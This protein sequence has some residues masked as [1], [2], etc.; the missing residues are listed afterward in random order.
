MQTLRIV[1]VQVVDS[2]DISI[3]FTEDLTPNL[4]P[5]NVSIISDTINIPES[6]VLTVTITGATLSLICQPLTPL[7]SYF[8]TL[9]SVPQHIF[10][11][12]NGD[13]RISEDGVSNKFLIT[14]PL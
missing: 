1:N 7:A 5:L 11:S 14:A 2:T 12:V 13:A 8:I 6:Q 4:F 10:E 9:Q 3:T